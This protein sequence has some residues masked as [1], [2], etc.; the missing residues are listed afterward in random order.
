[1]LTLIEVQ[2]RMTSTLI[3]FF[4]RDSQNR[5]IP[6][7]HRQRNNMRKHHYELRNCIC[8]RTLIPQGT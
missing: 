5:A 1:M 4:L 7:N 3:I 6:I 2:N 8:I